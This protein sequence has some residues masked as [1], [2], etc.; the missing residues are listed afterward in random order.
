MSVRANRSVAS[1]I[2][3]FRLCPKRVLFG[4]EGEQA[5]RGQENIEHKDK[6]PKETTKRLGD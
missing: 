6:K 4:F 5:K 1:S 2:L 3:E